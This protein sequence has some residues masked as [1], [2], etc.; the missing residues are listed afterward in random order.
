MRPERARCLA[1]LLAATLGAYQ[2]AIR[3]GADFVGTDPVST[4]DG[5]RVG[6][7]ENKIG[8]TTDVA[9]R[10]EFADRHVTR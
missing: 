8:G 4:R 7:H 5:V 6:R 9:A 3:A 1:L 10:P 2:V